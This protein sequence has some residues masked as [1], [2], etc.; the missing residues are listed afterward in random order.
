MNDYY[1]IYTSRRCRVGICVFNFQKSL[2]GYSDGFLLFAAKNKRYSPFCKKTTHTH[3][4][5][6]ETGR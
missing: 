3:T 5:I 4:K 2:F 6:I 1:K